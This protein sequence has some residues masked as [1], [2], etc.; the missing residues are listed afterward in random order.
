MLNCKQ[1]LTDRSAVSNISMLYRSLAYSYLRYVGR[2]GPCVEITLEFLNDN[3]RS[4]WVIKTVK[5]YLI[6]Y[7]QWSLYVP[8]SGHYM[9]RQQFYVLPS[10]CIYVFF[11][12][13][14]TNSDYF[15]IQH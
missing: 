14:R 9:Y 3:S 11:V 2:N 13:L 5:C 10:Q 8:H 15:T 6:L 1:V 4:M 12:D 7:S